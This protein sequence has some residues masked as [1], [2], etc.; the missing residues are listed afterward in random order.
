[1]TCRRA[2][3]WVTAEEQQVEADEKAAQLEPL[4]EH[5]PWHAHIKSCLKL[6]VL[7]F[8]QLHT[9]E[10]QEVQ[11]HDLEARLGVC[12]SWTMLLRRL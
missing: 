1:M 7:H 10:L 5:L 3:V 11:D 12:M 2:G 9:V 4:E 8:L 6:M